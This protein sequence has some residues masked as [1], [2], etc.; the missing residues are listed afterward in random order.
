M[1]VCERW[2]P[3]GSRRGV[4]EVGVRKNGVA[5]A[6]GGQVSEDDV[7]QGLAAENTRNMPGIGIR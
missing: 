5:P 3:G 2:T 6:P 7:A 1:V 4:L